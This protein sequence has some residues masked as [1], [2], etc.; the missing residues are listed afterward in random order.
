MPN[1]IT[2]N[3][4]RWPVMGTYIWP[5]SPFYASALSHGQVMTEMKNWIAERIAWLDANL[6]GEARECEIYLD[7]EQEIITS[8]EPTSETSIFIYPNP[9]SGVFSLTST[10]IIQSVQILTTNGIQVYSAQPLRN[11]FTAS[12]ELSTGIYFVRVR[13]AASVRILKLVVK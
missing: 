5:N 13:T 12:A 6:P 10:D 7:Y 2:R 9:G 3:F 1:A 8:I 4:Q 11:Y